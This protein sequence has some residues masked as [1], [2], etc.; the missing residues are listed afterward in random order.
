MSTTSSQPAL[1]SGVPLTARLLGWAGL[2]PFVALA[3]GM[4]FIP[5]VA[6]IAATLLAGYA[7]GILCFLLGIWWGIGVMRGD[8][9]PLLWSNGLFIALFFAWAVLHG[10]PFMVVAGLLFLVLLALERRL[11][12]F[13]PQPAYYAALRARLSVVAAASLLLGAWLHP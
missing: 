4:L 10:P 9:A 3:A 8:P 1:D 11:S 13:K 12:V 5:A 2:L 7:F 6:H